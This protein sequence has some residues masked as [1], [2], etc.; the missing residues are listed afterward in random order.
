M[1]GV[2]TCAL[3]ISKTIPLTASPTPITSNLVIAGSTSG[4]IT[5]VNVTDL[6]ILHTYDRE[7]AVSLKSPNNTTRLLLSSLC[8][9]NDNINLKFDD[10][11]AS[12]YA[13]IPCPPTT[14][15][16]YQAGETLA[17]FNGQT[18]IGTWQLQ[19]VDNITGNG[20]SLESWAIEVC[21]SQALLPVELVSFNAVKQQNKVAL[22]WQTASERN[23]KGFYIERS[24]GNDF[25][26]Q[27][28]GFV[29]AVTVAKPKNNYQFADQSVVPG[30]IYYYR[31]RQEDTDGHFVYSDVKSV[32][33]EGAAGLLQIAPNPARTAVSLSIDTDDKE[34]TYTVNVFSNDGRLVLSRVMPITEPID[35]SAWPDG[36]YTIQA[37]TERKIWTGKVVKI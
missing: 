9:D 30:N 15:L 24:T 11:V 8:L 28:I 31:L 23:N 19:I 13:S 1:T 20:G 2:Q 4:T 14:G 6:N 3:P 5:D 33:F 17:P 26:F 18:P 10:N 16:F 21:V 12:T 25:D 34:G 37:L 27:R 35:I 22:N 32:A 7:L 36:V 29:P